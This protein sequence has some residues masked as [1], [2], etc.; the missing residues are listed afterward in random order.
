M[1]KQFLNDRVFGSTY[2]KFHGKSAM[3]QPT[4]DAEILKYKQ[5][6]ELECT[7]YLVPLAVQYI[8]SWTSLKDD[9][10]YMSLVVQ[11]LKNLFTFIKSLNPRDT[12][13]HELYLW[14]K[15]H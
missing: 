10:Y 3:K 7:K 9:P 5:F 11:A 12:A 1:A 2:E 8:Q 14:P 6:N 4:R 15:D 13:H